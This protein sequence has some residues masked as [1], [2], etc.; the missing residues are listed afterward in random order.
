MQSDFSVL[1][2]YEVLSIHLKMWCNKNDLKNTVLCLN[3]SVNLLN[4]CKLMRQTTTERYSVAIIM[5]WWQFFSDGTIR[6]FVSC[7]ADKL[8]A[9]CQIKFPQ[10]C[11]IVGQVMKYSH[12]HLTILM[13]HNYVL[14]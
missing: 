9:N 3:G 11:V 4:I 1:F 13:G 7:L 8:T 12:G 14:F 2:A 10:N 5:F 6:P